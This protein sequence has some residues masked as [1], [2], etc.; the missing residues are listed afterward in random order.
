MEAQFVV[1]GS[2][3][4]GVCDELKRASQM[5][6]PLLRLSIR[7]TGKGCTRGGKK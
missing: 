3:L 6:K 1:D 5:Q 7:Y 4:P 2:L